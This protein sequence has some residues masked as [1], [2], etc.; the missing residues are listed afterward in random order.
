VDTVRAAY[1][2]HDVAGVV[3]CDKSDRY[4]QLSPSCVAFGRKIVGEDIS[5]HGVRHGRSPQ[6]NR[7][8]RSAYCVRRNVFGCLH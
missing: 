5:Q 4:D 8:V 2:D 1:Q 3:L 7:Q 6:R